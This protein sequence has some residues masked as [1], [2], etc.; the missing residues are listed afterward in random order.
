[1]IE[2]PN[3]INEASWNRLAAY[4][5]EFTRISLN[6]FHY[7]PYGPG[8]NE[9]GII[10]DVTGLD[11]LDIGCGGGQNS[12]VLSK[13]GAKSV[14]AIDQSESQLEFAR[15]LARREKREIRFLKCDMED[16]SIIRDDEFDL[17]VSSHAMNYASNISKVFVECARVLRKGGRLI[18]CMAHPIW[19]V[20]G[21]A[22]EKKDFTK[23]A[24][25]F[26]TKRGRWEWE[27][28][29]GER[30]ATF[31]STSWRLG[32]ILNALCDAGFVINRIEEPKGY[33]REEMMNL[34]SDAIP[35]SDAKWR[36]E[37]FIN[38]N[39]IIPNSLIVVAKKHTY[40]Q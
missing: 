36:N 18:T 34:P 14:T 31:E 2:S 37:E 19:L 35:Y 21:E 29:T 33:S 22:L 1:M 32:Q 11:V 24:S 12:I 30:I 6:N 27:K 38:A 13:H 26:D 39:Q 28:R 4:Y 16:L 8:D 20:L 7:N 9:L 3:K 40:D 23:I 15:K 17:I 10:G 5:Q 25:Y